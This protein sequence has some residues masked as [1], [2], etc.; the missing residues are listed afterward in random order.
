LL[1]RLYLDSKVG[2]RLFLSFL[3]AALLPMVGLALYAYV[4]VNE[5]LVDSHMRGLRQDSKTWAMNLILDLN[6]HAQALK[7]EAA[8]LAQSPGYKPHEPPGFLALTAM[9]KD[10][11]LTTVEQHH[12]ER[13]GV[14]LRMTPDEELGMLVRLD[15]TKE[16][17]YGRI[18][19]QELWINDDTPE[20]YCILS[21]DF[22]P[23]ICAPGITP[24][25]GSTWAGVSPTQNSDI[26]DWDVAGQKLFG[27]Y[28]NA[29]L[30]AAYAHPGFVALVAEPKDSLLRD[31]EQF[32]YFFLASTALTLSLALLL[33]LGQIRRQIQPLENLSTGTRRLA[34]GDFSVQVPVSG[35]DEFAGLAQSFNRMAAYLSHKFHLLRMLGELDRAIL[36]ASEM[37]FVGLAI[38]KHI[39]QAIPCDCAGIILLDDHGG[40]T[41]MASCDVGAPIPGNNWRFP[42]VSPFLP[43]SDTGQDWRRLQWNSQAPE[44]VQHF[45]NPRL[46]QALAFPARVSGRID[47]LL[48]L[49]YE[50][51]HEAEDEIIEAARSLTDR[52]AV[53]ASN[54][55]WEERLYH[56]AHYDA[57]TDL[58]NRVL[59]RDRIEQALIRAERERSSVA[60]ILV[61]LDNFK[62]INDSLGHSAGDELLVE[63]ASRLKTAIRSSDTLARLGGDEFI[64]LIPD[65]ERESE[66]SQLVML[67]KKLSATLSSPMAIAGR[68]VSVLASLGI[69]LYPK[70]ATGIEDLL[71][72]AD[73]AMYESK[74]RQPGGFRFFSGDMNAEIQ[75]HFELT[76]DL[77]EAIGHNELLLHF[78]PKVS[79]ADGR[80]MGAEALVRWQSPKRG[81]VPPGLFV[82]LLEEMGL[83]LWLDE[84]VLEQAC[85]QMSQWDHEGVHPIPVS[86]NLSPAN[87]HDEGII[88]KVQEALH[89]NGLQPERLELEILEATAVRQS[90]EIFSIMARLR[91]MN[92][93]IALDDFG[94]GYSSLVYLTQLPANVLKLDRAFIRGLATDQRQ[95]AIVGGIVALARVL[96]YTVVAEGVEEK[97]QRDL[98]ADMGC[99]LIQGYLFSPAIPADEFARLLRTPSPSL[100]AVE[101]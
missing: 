65:L 80:I 56:Q 33:S 57:L 88:E 79:S 11:P 48:I 82:P 87:F 73:T 20:R 61:D 29:H 55:A 42:D 43:G 68:R 75:A 15:G 3:A 93:N 35:N 86:V 26:V 52:L 74:R 45:G 78:Q 32:R 98:L 58:P 28:W 30:Q 94:T 85:A 62:Q 12:L 89:R 84:W 76:Q 14:V 72:M 10:A 51:P 49:G 2:R 101:P 37:E 23:Y 34:A 54:L 99:D 22:K 21:P 31:L 27:G 8:R 44:W 9:S 40:G 59:L 53:A 13:G 19:A 7:Q 90:E 17:L 47:S 18:N 64:I 95:Q 71:K 46:R 24:P 91:A 39:R 67:A 69:A 5:M 63:C 38:L 1:P 25:S 60:V 83:S 36:N 92:I 81:M 97:I 70:N 16:I 100:A 50:H 77:R 96:D 66:L 41:L 6:R 4:K